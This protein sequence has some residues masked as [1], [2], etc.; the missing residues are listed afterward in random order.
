[1]KK[2]LKSSNFGVS[3]KI[4]RLF[5]V[6]VRKDIGTKVNLNSDEEILS[7]YPKGSSY[8]PSLYDA[9]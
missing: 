6:G 1:L 3:Q 5:L 8:E 9:L 7:F 2:I 4:R